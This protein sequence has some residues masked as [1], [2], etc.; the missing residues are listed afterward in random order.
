MKKYLLIFISFFVVLLSCKK[1][2]IDLH[3]YVGLPDATQSGEDIFGCL[4]NGKPWVAGSDYLTIT[5][6]VG[7]S[8]DEPQFL[9]NWIPY[10]LRIS[11]KN[12]KKDKVSD[13]VI[14]D[15]NIYFDFS[16]IIKKG[17]YQSFAD[18]DNIKVELWNTGKTTSIYEIDSLAP[19]YLEITKLD[20]VN[21]FVS[22]IF[23]FK[24]KRISDEKDTIR[25]SHGR[26]DVV[27]QPD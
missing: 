4:A 22:G 19:F 7:G 15:Q 11:A 6:K 1:D 9:T 23:D 26:F 24:V 16:P 3:K 8:Y 2:G 10:Y 5:P 14:I 18:F 27:Y 25:L 17:I 21:N 20:T 13:N 12:L